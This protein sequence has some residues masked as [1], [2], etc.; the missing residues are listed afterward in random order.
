MN[1]T[2]WC[3]HSRRT[4][5]TPSQPAWPSPRNE[6]RWSP[7]TDS[8]R[9]SDKRFVTCRPNEFTD[10]SPEALEDAHRSALS[11]EHR[12]STIST[13]TMRARISAS[14]SRWTRRS[15][16]SL[17][18]ARILR[19]R[20]SRSDTAF[21]N[22]PDGKGCEFVGPRLK[23]EKLFGTGVGIAFRKADADTRCKKFNAALKTVRE[24]GTYET[25]NKR[26]FP[27]SVY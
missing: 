23:D 20:R 27:F 25:I 11:P 8:I 10:M 12:A 24:N 1:M 4:R 16:I 22:K 13:P 18:A 3:Q 26:Y 19:W 6:K 17:P 2:A 14:T 5:S 7:L 21:T 15:R 9:S